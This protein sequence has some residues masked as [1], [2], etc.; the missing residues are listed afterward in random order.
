MK[1]HNFT[2]AVNNEKKKLKR[3]DFLSSGGEYCET[4]LFYGDKIKKTMDET[5]YEND[6]QVIIIAMAQQTNVYAHTHTIVRL[7]IS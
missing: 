2:T 3:I 6:S 1:N 7:W 4:G 5:I